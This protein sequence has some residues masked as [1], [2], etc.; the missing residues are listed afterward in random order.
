MKGCRAASVLL[1]LAVFMLSSLPG[2]T[3]RQT[4]VP[5]QHN[6]IKVYPSYPANTGYSNLVIR[7]YLGYG[8]TAVKSSAG[9]LSI[10]P[11]NNWSNFVGAAQR[12]V[13]YSIKNVVL[14]KEVPQIAQ[15]S[16]VF[17]KKTVY[18][19][20]TS[21]IR[22][23]WPLLF[24]VPGTK[25]TLTI[26]YG[27]SVAYDDD[28][29][30]PNPA[31]YVH[32]EV[33]TWEVATDLQRMKRLIEVLHSVPY[34]KSQVPLIFDETLY[35]ELISRLN[36]IQTLI[37]RNDFLTATLKLGE[38]EMLVADR[39][40]ETFPDKPD[41]IFNGGGIASDHCYP[42]CC[43][44]LASAEYVLPRLAESARPAVP[45]LVV[46]SQPTS[47]PGFATMQPS[48]DIGG[49]ASG[50]VD[51]ASV[52]WQNNRGG[53]GICSGTNS[54]TAFGIPLQPGDN[55]ITVTATDINGAT[56]TDSVLI[57]FNS[58]VQFLG[59][60]SCKPSSIFVGQAASVRV[61][62]P[63]GANPPFDPSS[64]KLLQVDSTGQTIGV[65]GTMVDNGDLSKGDDIANDGI[66]SFI[67]NFT[68][69]AEGAIYLRVQAQ[70][71]GENCPIGKSA[72]RELS[73]TKNISDSDFNDILRIE[74]QGLARFNSNAPA[75]GCQAAM[76]DTLAWIRTQPGVIQSGTSENGCGIWFLHR[77]G[78]L[79]G[80]FLSPNGQKDS[81]VRNP[82]PV[83]PYEYSPY[84]E[85]Y[86]AI[87]PTKIASKALGGATIT[88][89]RAVCLA[90]YADQLGLD[91][92]APAIHSILAASGCPAFDLQP[93]A[94]NTAVTV[95]AFKNLNGNGVIVIS[96]MGDCFYGGLTPDWQSKFGWTTAGGQC[97]VLTREAATLANKSANEADL[98][99]GRLAIINAQYAVL[100]SFIDFYLEGL[101][102]S[103]VY[104]SSCRSAYNNSLANAFLANGA[105]AFFGYS[106]YVQPAWAKARGVELFNGLVFQGKTG[107]EAFIPNQFEAD[108][109]PAWFVMFGDNS[110]SLT[111]TGIING[112]FE[113]GSLQGW[114]ASGDAR[115]LAQ[116][117][118]LFPQN[119]VYMAILSTGLGSI[120]NSI[121]SLEQTFCIPAGATTLEFKYN[122]ISEEF[123][124]WCFAGF[125]DYF[126]ASL[127]QNSVTST[128]LSVNVDDLCPTVVPVGINFAGG[129]ST[130]FMT[131]WQTATVNV[132]A[133]AGT[134]TPIVLK[135]T[136]GDVGDSDYDTAVLIDGVRLY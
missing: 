100:P 94:S 92:D 122:F 51:I 121:S 4:V 99:A 12:Q 132:A 82:A 73:V 65:L 86:S 44:L 134:G 135:F 31:G 13:P 48:V 2:L 41:V 120:N 50:G 38:F 62:V 36:E 116:L 93:L 103:L 3:A 42:A 133:Y 136:V 79:G 25:F 83:P 18:Q 89:R 10:V 39:C 104:V 126:Y 70:G 95:N 87:G 54:W 56:A 46:I 123:K 75:L 20:G 26:L 125:Q 108:E 59:P 64:V 16:D 80:L 37:S 96:S 34:A 14:A 88:S 85:F 33:W 23:W 72:I 58:C 22:L 107:S 28:G 6:T 124:E 67:W 68:P 115:I 49:S 45:P 57:T 21:A 52:V 47:D 131:G 29:P 109:D 63:I 112:S 1:I 128:F 110:I 98:M 113:T 61:T 129:D 55:I 105:A 71:I 77:S 84:S 127:M 24:E 9:V 17:T 11:G 117:G 90:P 19:R 66:F 7:G 35:P 101:P 40:S 69:S 114:T 8:D 30:G 27:T 81:P 119:G 5:V 32:T 78:V 43:L 15:C 111:D 102:N 91:D 130:T 74:N 60:P 106:D 118:P 76:Q 97:L 53:S